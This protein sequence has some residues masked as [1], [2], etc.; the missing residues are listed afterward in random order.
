VIKYV[1]KEGVVQLEILKGEVLGRLVNRSWLKLYR[2]NL[3]PTH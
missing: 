3:P 2:E 1:T